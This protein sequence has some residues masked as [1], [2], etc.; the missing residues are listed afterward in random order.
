MRNSLRG[1]SVGLAAVVLMS[2]SLASAGTLDDV[3]K[4]GHLIC[5]INTGLVGF[6]APDD[7]G[8]WK[9]FDVDVCRAVAAAVFGDANKLKY[10]HLTGKTRFTALRSA[11]IDMLSRN[12]TWTFSRD[13]DLQLTFVGVNYYDGQGFMAPKKLGVK[14]AKDLAGASV[15]IQ[16]G[17]TTELN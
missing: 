13:V 12:T 3:R 9:G 7:K 16:T 15:C 17:T 2:A 6:A 4:R 11:E 14:S 8:V 1:F 5:G 10:K